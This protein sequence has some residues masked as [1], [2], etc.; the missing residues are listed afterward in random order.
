MGG[1]LK[2]TKGIPELVSVEEAAQMLR[3]SRWTV[4]SW[5]TRPDAR[6]AS[7]KVGG[8][9]LIARTDIED[10]LHEAR[11]EANA[12]KEANRD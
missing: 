2:T 12:K 3:I 1:A 9:R 11:Q 8:R 7:Y 10:L 4:Y 6:I 5:V